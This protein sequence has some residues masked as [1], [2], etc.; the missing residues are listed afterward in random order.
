MRNLLLSIAHLL[1]VTVV[2]MSVAYSVVAKAIQ[3]VAVK[4]SKV[5]ETLMDFRSIRCKLSCFG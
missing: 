2:E 5:H 4:A 3:L 1:Q